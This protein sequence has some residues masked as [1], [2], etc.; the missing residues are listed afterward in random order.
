MG[1]KGFVCFKKWSFRAK[2]G[3]G[4]SV[5]CYLGQKMRRVYCRNPNFTGRMVKSYTKVDF[6][7]ENDCIPRFEKVNLREI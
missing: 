4:L 1:D 5:E 3:K 6:F 7:R 2:D